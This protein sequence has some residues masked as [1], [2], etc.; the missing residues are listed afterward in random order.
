MKFIQK[1]TEI[2]YKHIGTSYTNIKN[3]QKNVQ[4]PHPG[5][6]APRGPAEGGPVD[7]VQ[8]FVDFSYLYMIFLYVYI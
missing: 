3:L 2:I 1:Y 8:F 6:E 5:R 4:N 7:F